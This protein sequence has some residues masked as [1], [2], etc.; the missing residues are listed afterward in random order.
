MNTALITTHLDVPN[1]GANL[2]A[3]ATKLFLVKNNISPTYAILKSRSLDSQYKKNVS[4]RQLNLHNKFIKNNF[5]ISPKFLEINEF[6]CFLENNFFDYYI[7]G[8][9]AVFRLNNNH[10]GE[11]WDLNYPNPFWLNYNVR[12]K[13]SFSASAMGSNIPKIIGS[14]SRTSFK[15]NLATF[16]KL[17][18]RDAWTYQCLKYF[19]IEADICLDPVFLLRKL[20]IE[21]SEWCTR[22]KTGQYVVISLPK[23]Y[24]Q[25][26]TEQLYSLFYQAG[27]D[28]VDIGTPEDEKISNL[29]PITWYNL[30][31]N[32]YGY[33]GVRFHP[34]VVAISNQKPVFCLDMYARHYNERKKSKSY[35][36]LK[37]FNLHD[38][39]ADKLQQTLIT[40]K[41]IVN[42]ILKQKVVDSDILDKK[43]ERTFN[44][45]M[46]CIS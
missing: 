15:N 27:L 4:E 11:R 21:S 10:Q 2:Q 32:S 39:Y 6:N 14:E 38:G 19:G 12:N 44:I 31:A 18:V 13:I 43:I 46:D 41:K 20:N 34:L 37:E 9:D 1:Y 17:T 16:K 25:K 28:V 35:L 29:D 3:Y 45:Y 5:S 42:S 33:V 26:F 22:V 24:S 8:S 40:P 36:L 23:R 30:I 7:T